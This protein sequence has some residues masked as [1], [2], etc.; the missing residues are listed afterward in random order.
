[1]ET[2]PGAELRLLPE[3]GQ[4]DGYVKD[5]LIYHSIVGSAE[6][7]YGYFL[8][9]TTLESTFIVKLNGDTIQCMWATDRADAN[10]RSNR[11]AISV[12]TEDNRNPDSFPWTD[13]QL[14]EL[15]R[16]GVWAVEHHAITPVRCPG[17]YEP[18]IGYHSMHG[19]P[20]PWTPARGKT[21]P[22][23]VRREQFDRIVLP[24]IIEAVT[25]IRQGE[26]Q[27]DIRD[28]IKFCQADGSPVVW[29]LNIEDGTRE[30]IET[31]DARLGLAQVFNLDPSV[32][33]VHADVI[34]QFRVRT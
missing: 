8:N 2:L 28:A 25:G 26:D 31:H 22:G 18:G 6:G 20:S 17:P 3:A 23:V 7:A 11:R 29:M 32:E 14:D 27:M 9:H 24:R 21:C 1:M 19:A 12:E 30:G 15:V 13:D 34:N 5:Q 10:S 33:K 16:I 4:P